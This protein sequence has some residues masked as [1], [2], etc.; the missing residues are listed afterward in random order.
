M[1]TVL[2]AIFAYLIDKFFGDFPFKLHPL[3][4]IREWVEFF[5][6]KFY[7]DTVGRGILLLIFILTIVGA[8]SIAIHL[9]LII[10]PTF[11]YI[12]ASS[13][14]ASIFITHE[15]LNNAEEET[16][17][18]NL[19]DNI[20]A[21]LFY[22]LLFNLPGIIIYKTVNTINSML[23]QNNEKYKNYVKAGTSLGDV[24]NYIP[25]K[26]VTMLQILRSKLN[27]NENI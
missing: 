4:L 17:E 5:E 8:F 16:Y 9:Y 21:P 25:S 10:L 14:I 13:L 19:R 24:F 20:V 18:I 22:L 6:E 26:I 7:K 27:N 23:Q 1:S 11:I 15:E 12:I 2:I 3:A